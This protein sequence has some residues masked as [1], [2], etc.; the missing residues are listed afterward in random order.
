MKAAVSR[1]VN[2]VF[3]CFLASLFPKGTRVTTLE[4]EIIHLAANRAEHMKASASFLM[5]PIQ[6]SL[7][8][9]E[10]DKRMV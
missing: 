6:S 3:N 5:E 7:T 4:F 2:D 10:A 1:T 9:V 8:C